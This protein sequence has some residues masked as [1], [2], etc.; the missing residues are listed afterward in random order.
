MRSVNNML[1]TQ[2][3]KKEDEGN[4]NDEEDHGREDDS[5]EEEDSDKHTKFVIIN[6]HIKFLVAKF[7]KAL[8]GCEVESL[9]KRKN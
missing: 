3:I 4:E 2:L 7:F 8:A 5:K 9:I 6:Q 1:V